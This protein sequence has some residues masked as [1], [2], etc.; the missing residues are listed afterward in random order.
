MNQGEK[1]MTKSLSTVSKILVALSLFVAVICGPLPLKA[2]DHREAPK[3]DD[4]P[5]GDITD[6][7]LFTDPNDPSRVV[8]MMNVNPFGNPSENPSFSF[9]PDLL[10]QFKIDNTGDAREDKVIQILFTGVGQG[11]TVQVFGPDRPNQTGARN[12]L[13]HGAPSAS[14]KFGQVFGDPSGVLVFA[15]LRDDPMVFDGGHFYRI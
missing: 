4:I 5:E 1:G 11:Q 8:M 12:A 9:S 10:Y 7:F 15:G 3:V 2:A 13:L 14:G 6:V